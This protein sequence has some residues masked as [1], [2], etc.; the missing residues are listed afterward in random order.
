MTFERTYEWELIRQIAT[1]PK[2][3][4]GIVDDFSPS[5]SDWEPEHDDRVWYVLAKSDGGSVLGMFI[6]Y[7]ENPV[8]WRSHICMLPESWGIPARQACR[9][10]FQW[11]WA[12]SSCLRIIGSIPACNSLGLGF[13]MQCGMERFGVNSKS[14]Q[15]GG[16]LFDLIMLGISKPETA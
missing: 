16:R 11:L 12:N 2:I 3:W 15:K 14:V 13:A 9:E 6:F 7:P 1:H 4:P 8:C 5:P 10:V